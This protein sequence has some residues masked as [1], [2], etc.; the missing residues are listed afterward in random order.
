MNAPITAQK[1]NNSSVLAAPLGVVAALLVGSVLL[2]LNTQLPLVNTDRG[3]FIALAILGF[4]MCSVGGIGTAIARRG[5]KGGVTILGSV[6]GVLALAFIVLVLLGVSLPFIATD[7]DAI[8]ALVGICMVKVL[9]E[10]ADHLR[11]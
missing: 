7:R 4:A 8:I 1:Q 9:I 11:K 6:L 5:W 2:G 10:A 3:A